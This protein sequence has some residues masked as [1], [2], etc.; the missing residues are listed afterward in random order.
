MRFAGIPLPYRLIGNERA[1]RFH[2][3]KVARDV[4]RH[5]R[6]LETHYDVVHCW[7]LGSIATLRAAKSAGTATVL[8]RPNAH[9]AF[10]YEVVSREHE[11]LGVPVTAGH[12]HTPNP[13]RLRIE[14]TEYQSADLLACPSDFVAGTFLAR[15]V[16][17]AKIGRHQYGYDPAKF[18]PG[19]VARAEDHR[20]TMVFVGR[21]EPRKGLHY[22]LEAWHRAGAPA[23]GRFIICGTYVPG[24][25]KVLSR[26]L[27]GAS[28]E[29]RGH[30]A[31]V[32][33]E[34]R[35]AD[36]LVLPSIEE[37]SALVTYEARASG[38]V[39]LV[40]EAAGAKLQD[41]RHGF[42]HRV[43]DVDQLASQLHTLVSDRALLRRMRS[44]S[45]A[46]TAGLTWSAAA[47][48]QCALYEQAIRVSLRSKDAS[49]GT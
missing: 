10:A 21:C 29:E 33:G 25:R 16:D 20:F 6:W 42:V 38:C 15:G 46:D 1:F 39:L 35:N 43:G 19:P 32:S 24:Y 40:S 22:A 5:A 23:H 12:S 2:D 17:P 11:K 45:I 9:T 14:E 13:E 48:L 7:P 44:D 27:D 8:E 37:G 30:L 26:W 18:S 47:E 31:D 34:M 3:E 49:G 4:T 36:V 28:V 41:G